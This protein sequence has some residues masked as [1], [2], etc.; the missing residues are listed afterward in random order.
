MEMK[1]ILSNIVGL[2]IFVS[3]SAV[4]ADGCK[5][6]MQCKGDRIC[7]QGICVNPKY[8]DNTPEYPV[9][10]E[11]VMD[12]DFPQYCCTSAGKLGPYSNPD[13]RT[14]LPTREHDYCFG[15]TET[16]QIEHGVACY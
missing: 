2:L 6:D 4:A 12:D 14:G 15:A 9:E 13:I 10:A 11:T 16:G 7:E 5:F 3:V 1:I 8:D